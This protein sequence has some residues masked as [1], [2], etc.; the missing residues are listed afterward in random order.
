MRDGLTIYLVRHGETDWNRDRRYQGQMDIPLNARGRAQAQRNGAALRPFLPQ[1]AELHFIASPLGR[2]RETMEIIRSELGLPPK[3]Y[4][5]E[6]RLKE[7][8]YGH[9]EGQ[10]QSDLPVIDPEG[11]IQRAVDPFRWR[12]TG[13]ESYADLH[14]R[15]L[16]WLASVEYGC[17]VAAHGGISRCLRAAVLGLDPASIP[18]LDCPQDRVLVL[19]AKTMRWI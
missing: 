3:D 19:T 1:I 8:N 16:D 9:W 15:T 14:A 18:D 7:L 6:P 13:G 4:T 5:I 17:V 2:A 11:L 10:L 12:P